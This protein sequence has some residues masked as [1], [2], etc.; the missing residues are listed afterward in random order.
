MVLAKTLIFRAD[1]RFLIFSDIGS[2]LI[3][4][5]M[6]S[7]ETSAVLKPQVGTENVPTAILM[8]LSRRKLP[9]FGAQQFIDKDERTILQ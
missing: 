6:A 2:I 9:S 5:A 7:F 3:K 1:F 4:R 8:V